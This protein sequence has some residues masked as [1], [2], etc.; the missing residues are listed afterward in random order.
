MNKKYILVLIAGIFGI[1]SV[2]FDQRCYRLEK[3]SSDLLSQINDSAA[4]K[5]FCYAT[6]E[7][8]AHVDEEIIHLH[9]RLIDFNSNDAVDVNG[10]YNDLKSQTYDILN[11]LSKQKDFVHIKADG[12]EELMHELR[13]RSTSLNTEYYDNDNSLFDYTSF[14]HED[15]EIW[16]HVCFNNLIYN[17]FVLWENLI[18]KETELRSEYNGII[19]KRQTAIISSMISSLISIFL[20]IVFFKLANIQFTAS[21]D[22][23]SVD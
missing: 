9:T 10:F 3:K 5:Q 17:S 23:S 19:Y 22:P 2:F 1:L 21:K 12:F 6:N 13:T 7:H 15:S 20:I 14:G 18:K 4:L 16:W 11:D 8:L